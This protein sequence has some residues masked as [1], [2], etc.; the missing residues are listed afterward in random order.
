MPQATATDPPATPPFL[1]AAPPTLEDFITV[2]G[3]EFR[4][5]V[6]LFRTLIATH[7]A[8]FR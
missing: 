7:N 4:A 8:L 2:S 6:Q 5:M 1:L 3:L